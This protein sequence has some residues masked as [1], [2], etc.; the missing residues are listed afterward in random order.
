MT[1]LR[2]LLVTASSFAVA[3]AISPAFA[4]D[5]TTQSSD[6]LRQGEIVVTGT[7]TANRTALETAVPVDV[8]P[9]EELTETGRVELNQILATTVPSFN[10]NQT[11]I[12]DGTDI[13]R[14]ATLRGLSPDQ[15]LVLLNGKRRHISALININ[16]SVGRGSA[17]VDLN[18]IPT[19]A[20][21]NVQVLRDGAS[22]QYGS[23]AIAG[24]I[25]VI[26][27][28]A[29]HGGGLNIRYGAHV[30][31]L[32]GLDRSEVDGQTTN[33][34]GWAG[35]GLGNNGFLTVSGE[36][37]LRQRSNRA[38][39]D[40]RQQ[41]PDT[42]AYAE[43]ERTFD[44][45]NHVYG[46]GR[47]ENINFFFNSGYTLNN[48]VELYAFGGV[49]ERE[50][51]SP[52]FY[53]RA[54][55]SR[56]IPSIY[57]GGFLPIIG[58]D[59]TDYSLGGGFRGTAS[60]WDYD[61]SAVYG[62]NELDY[63]VNNSLNVSLG[64]DSQTSFDAGSLAFD[65]L[66]INA[67]VVKTFYNMLPGETS[68]AFGVEYR[69]ETFEITAGEPASYIQGPFPGAAGSQVFPGFTPESEVDEGRDAAGIYG[70]IEWVPNEK[71]LLSA[72]VRYE[73]YS[74]FGDAVTGKVAGRYEFT[75][76]IAVRGAIATGFRAPSLQQQYF[77]AISTNFI[78]GVPFEVG[79]FPATS[80]AA[81]ALGGGQ[82]DAE[83]STSYSLGTVITP[84]NDWFVTID[85]Y[86]INIDDQIFLT[87]NLGGDDVDD[88]LADA[89]VTGVQRVRFFQNGIETETKG[90]DIVT[91]Y[92]FDFDAMGTLDV[93]AAFNY[94]K[95][96]VTYVPEN[97]VIP[98]LTLFG[99]DRTL[100]LEESAPETKLILNADYS[101][102]QAD[103]N[104]RATRY[105]D[106]LVPST[107]P[108][109]DFTLESDWILD[110]SV[111]FHVSEKFSVGIGADNILDEYPTMT[112]DGLSF[113]GIF[114]YSSRS[115]YGFSGRFVYARASYNW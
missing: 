68:L 91:K 48:G 5:D 22:A 1:K 83:E 76:Q 71:T 110:A 88:V 100:T 111:D 38:G 43:A 114:P 66:T 55:D 3:A 74:D 82:L 34:G 10:F 7:R 61:V 13:I 16:G 84:T 106:V 12:N 105:G 15:T 95:T 70:E 103:F 25:N 87:E 24:V 98:S 40:P 67:D 19:S 21:G 62:S 49:Q 37:S 8:F 18:S 42:P 99:R 78:D 30:T 52:G 104:V 45:L 80:P 115:P 28:E 109:N 58:G 51:E 94:S 33:I 86:Q 6:E 59:V 29:D 73:D 36:Y 85:A 96:E 17:A 23:D 57:P 47:M 46:N 97:T 11:A 32:E 56:N 54:I 63:S 92:G 64:P 75:D 39:L 44:R 107:N 79:T 102:Q 4:Q 53:R 20:I 108:D 101:Y 81:L 112:P 90:V 93:S 89:G 35:F 65:Q 9:V 50:A 60:G 113:N 69:D 31:D 14:P 77:T 41:F 26:L 72:A 27:R 2:T